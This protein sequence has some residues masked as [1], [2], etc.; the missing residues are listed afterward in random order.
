VTIL[1]EL[2]SASLNAVCNT[3]GCFLSVKLLFLF[4]MAIV[5]VLIVGCVGRHGDG[6]VC[7]WDMNVS[8]TTNLLYCLNT[9]SI[10]VT[11]ADQQETSSAP[12]D[13]DW[14]PFR[15]VSCSHSFRL[16][17]TESFFNMQS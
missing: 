4:W 2:F 3:V 7:F 10:F 6:K 1:Y 15:K 14:P 16:S 13:D 17:I 8:A 9:A 11:N 12:A 5:T